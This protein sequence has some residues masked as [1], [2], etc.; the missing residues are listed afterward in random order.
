[1]TY[2]TKCG[3]KLY[4]NLCRL[5]EM[6]AARRAPGSLTD[7]E[8]F[9]GRGTLA[10]QFQGEEWYLEKITKRYEQITG[11]RPNYNAVY[12][13]DLADEPGDPAGFVDPTEGRRHIKKVCR[14]KNTTCRGLVRH[15]HVELDRDPLAAAKKGKIGPSLMKR[16]MKERL[17]RNPDLK[18]LSK[19]ELKEKL[20]AEHT[21]KW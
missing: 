14:L 19:R 18:K 5:C 17:K 21:V 2:C 16:L 4:G 11:Q 12:V 8:F 10:D 6:F 1:M 15:D 7:R 9:A 20:T 3:G 13:P